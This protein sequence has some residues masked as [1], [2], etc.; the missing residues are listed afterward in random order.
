VRCRRIES[1]KTWMR[2]PTTCV[3]D[4]WTKQK[5]SMHG[6]WI[7]IVR[8]FGVAKRHVVTGSLVSFCFPARGSV[9]P[10]YIDFI[11]S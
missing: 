6:A 5:Q 1:S 10:F 7:L 11:A 4:T 3:V 9:L 2:V 8:C